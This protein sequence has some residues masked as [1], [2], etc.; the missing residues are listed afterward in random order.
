MKFLSKKLISVVTFATAGLLGMGNTSAA[1]NTINPAKEL[2]DANRTSFRSAFYKQKVAFV[3]GKL[4]KLDLSNKDQVLKLFVDIFYNYSLSSKD[5]NPELNIDA[6]I[7]CLMK[8]LEETLAK[9]LTAA[10][11]KGKLNPT[12]EIK[13]IIVKDGFSGR[14]A[15]G[16]RIAGGLRELVNSVDKD[17]RDLKDIITAWG[18]FHA[19]KF[20]EIFAMTPEQKAAATSQ[21]S[22]WRYLNVLNPRNW[23]AGKK[24]E[25]SKPEWFTALVGN[26]TPENTGILFA[27]GFDAIEVVKNA[28]IAKKAKSEDLTQAHVALI[29]VKTSQAKDAPADRIGLINKL[30]D[31]LSVISDLTKEQIDSLKGQDFDAILL[32]NGF[33]IAEIV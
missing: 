1:V 33:D 20:E 6:K 4:A 19:A 15:E 12:A 24:V 9:Y 29:R 25:I 7:A 14:I 2:F 26:G 27:E 8:G 32:A 5:Q 11:L 13:D 18:N 17:R 23:F 10:L 21:S 3:T 16:G 28:L 22:M 30:C 31:C